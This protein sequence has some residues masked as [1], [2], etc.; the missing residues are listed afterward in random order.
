MHKAELKEGLC[1]W[2]Q[3]VI[4]LFLQELGADTL[5]LEKFKRYFLQDHAFIKDLAKL[6]NLITAKTLDLETTRRLTGSLNNVLTR[7]KNLFRDTFREWARS[8]N[9]SLNIEQVP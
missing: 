9:Q 5:P 1:L 4:P 6:V 2:E 7:D 3:I 8:P